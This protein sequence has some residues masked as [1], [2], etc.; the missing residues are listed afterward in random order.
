A[1]ILRNGRLVG[2]YEIAALPRLEMVSKMVGHELAALEDLDREAS[3]GADARAGSTPF[4]AAH[5]VGRTGAVA[6]A[7]LAVYPGEIVGLAGLLGSGRTELARLLFGADRADSGTVAVAG[8]PVRLRS[9]LAA[10]AERIAFSSENR[11]S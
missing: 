6:P 9:P 2:E 10:I 11:K 5:G 3:A 4:L 7:D 8:R 1:T